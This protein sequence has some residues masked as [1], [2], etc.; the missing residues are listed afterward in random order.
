LGSQPAKVVR[1]AVSAALFGREERPPTE[2]LDCAK[3][4]GENALP[5]LLKKLARECRQKGGMAWGLPS[6]QR[7]RRAAVMVGKQSRGLRSV[8]GGAVP[9]ACSAKEK[10]Q[11]FSAGCE[12]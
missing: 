6:V 8:F 12:G 11:V 3:R 2:P 4:S 1:T 7:E 9:G 10:P 5:A